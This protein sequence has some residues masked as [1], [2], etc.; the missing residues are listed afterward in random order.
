MATTK[1]ILDPSHSEINFKVRHLMV[2]WVSGNFKKF[3]TEVETAG[4]DF[5]T[6]KVKFTADI[7][8]ISTNNEQR[9]A[10]LKNG[11]FFDAANH[12]QLV[13]ESE[14]LEKIDAENYKLHGT[15]TMRG[16]TRKVTLNAEF[17]GIAKDPWGNIRTGF[18][19]T[20][21]INRK[22]Y[23]VSFGMLTE[24]GGALLGDDVTINANVEFVKQ[25]VEE[26]VEVA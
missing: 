21:K 14:R 25:V 8:S 19:I 13:F 22:E 16:N 20:G 11:D 2:S 5:A 15:L 6:A 12:P 7:D 1:W 18:T 24:T 26:A 3:D 17:G 10:H 9:D 4:D 23:G